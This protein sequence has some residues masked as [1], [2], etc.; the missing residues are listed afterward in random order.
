MPIDPRMCSLYSLFH[1]FKNPRYCALLWVSHQLKQRRSNSGSVF[2]E[3][4][5]PATDTSVKLD[6]MGDVSALCVEDG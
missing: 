6:E 3:V 4:P 2:Q 5:Y 1:S